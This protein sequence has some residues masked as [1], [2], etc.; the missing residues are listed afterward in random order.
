[1]SSVSAHKKSMPSIIIKVYINVSFQ[2]Q[3]LKSYFDVINFTC[4]CVSV[5]TS[6][7]LPRKDHLDDTASIPQIYVN[8][9]G[10]VDY[11]S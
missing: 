2:K 1:M 7:Y 9:G 8:N 6:V 4:A 5:H 11:D 10:W 3:V